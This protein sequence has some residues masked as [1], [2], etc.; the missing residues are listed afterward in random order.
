MTDEINDYKTP[1]IVWVKKITL[2]LYL[3]TYSADPKLDN[4]SIKRRL[5]INKICDFSCRRNDRLSDISVSFFVN[6]HLSSLNH[7]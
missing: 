4:L 5:I 6:V 2:K 7:R 3:S 1:P